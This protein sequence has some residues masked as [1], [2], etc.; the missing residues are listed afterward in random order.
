MLIINYTQ[1][2]DY[3]YSTQKLGSKLGLDNITYLLNL[4]GNPHKGLRVIHIA[5]TNGKGSTT[6]MLTSVLCGA[7]YRVGTYVSPFIT[8]FN[9]RI[10]MN[11]NYIHDDDL[12]ELTTIVKEKIDFMVAQGHAHPTEFEI[13]TAIAFLYYKRQNCDFVVLEVG[14]GGRL[15]STNVIENPLVS[16][17]TSISFDHM[18]I[19]GD[20]IEKIAYEKC[21][22][23]KNGG[24]VVCYPIQKDGAWDV[25]KQTCEE[26][27]AT[28]SI[29]AMPENID[30]TINGNVLDYPGFP[31]IQTSL[32]GEYQAYNTATVLAVLEILREKHGIAIDN[33]TIYYGI[34]HTLWAGRF[35]VLS[36]SPLVII[37]GGH[38]LS[39]VEAFKRSFEKLTANK[40]VTIVM[41][42]F[43]DKEYRE[44]VRSL[45]PLAD[46]FIATAAFSPR[47]ATA[48]MIADCADSAKSVFVC[49]T[50]QEAIDM[51][52]EKSSKDD[53]IA[54]VGSLFLI[55][56]I[57]QYL[58]DKLSKL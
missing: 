52:I 35:E 22:I 57:R 58:I 46:N 15:D 38:N 21:G 14:L 50:T 34:S 42:M 45:A 1:T 36:Q 51:A 9:E 32:V 19:L 17:I 56:D 11:G 49:P 16:V 26:K 12:A 24:Q 31:H 7:G 10:G 44:C 23:I 41:G 37:D 6:A 29:A 13:I 40:K 48:Q 55:S 28:L 33:E 30:S 39:G 47:A 54:V 53:V 8:C 20:T 27:N 5:G 2:I 4:L 3:I 18:E 43:K 25:I